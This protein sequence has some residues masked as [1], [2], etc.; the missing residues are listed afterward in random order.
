M[1]D[2]AATPTI[3]PDDSAR[4]YTV[5][6]PDGDASLRHIAVVGDTYTILVDG[7]Q[8][9]G[10]Y[11]LIDMLI[12]RGGGPPPHRHDFEEVFIVLEGEIEV[13]F[14]GEKMT[15][16]AGETLNVPANAPHRFTNSSD[17][18]AR[19][20]CTCIPAGQEEFFLEVGDAVPTRTSP[21][22]EM[23]DAERKARMDKAMSLASK[24]RTEI[25]MP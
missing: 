20:L 4:N 16:K 3:P 11:C 18:P 19:L 22:P 14:R 2:A 9:Q 6:R 21:P 17:A 15:L 7:V 23:D 1:P 24:Y 8:T 5:A 12:P 25:L 10:R 13:T